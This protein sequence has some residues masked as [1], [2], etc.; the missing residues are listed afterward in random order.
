MKVSLFFPLGDFLRLA[1]SLIQFDDPGAGA[2]QMIPVR[3]GDAIFARRHP[4]IAFEQPGFGVDEF[5]LWPDP[6]VIGDVMWHVAVMAICLGLWTFFLGAWLT[7]K[8]RR[9]REEAELRKFRARFNE[10]ERD[11]QWRSRRGPS[12]VKSLQPLPRKNTP[13]EAFVFG[14]SGRLRPPPGG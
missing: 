5:P 13:A 7:P 2:V 12:R 3:D 9:E 4:V 1:P 6:M 10:A 8:I 14:R 11:G